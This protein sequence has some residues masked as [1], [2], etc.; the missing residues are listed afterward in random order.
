M[1]E[2]KL[3]GDLIEDMTMKC[4]KVPEI[5]SFALDGDCC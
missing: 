1:P 3:F 5:L 4:K 2:L